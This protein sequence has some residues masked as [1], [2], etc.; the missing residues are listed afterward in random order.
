MELE[1]GQLITVVFIPQD[2]G[3]AMYQTILQECRKWFYNVSSQ[4]DE[5]LKISIEKDDS[6]CLIG[7]IDSN[8]YISQITVS[9]SG[10]KPYRYVEFMI[11]D[12]DKDAN[13]SPVFWY[14]DQ[15]NSSV[16]DIIDNLNKGLRIV[17]S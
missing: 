8:R 3:I 5:V 9:E 6:S 10:F 2:K 1:G 14:G 17:L 16:E 15:D 13:Q 7:D 4:Y 12:L 11:Y